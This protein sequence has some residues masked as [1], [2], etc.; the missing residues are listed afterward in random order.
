MAFFW[1]LVFSGTVN[2][3]SGTYLI[4]NNE[5]GCINY[6]SNGNPNDPRKKLDLF[7]DIENAP[8]IRVCE[9]KSVDYVMNGANIANVQWSAAGG[10]VTSVSGT[11]N[12][13]ATVAWGAP[14]NG[15]LTLTITYSN[16]SQATTSVCIE[17]IN[18]P[19]ALFEILGFDEPVFCL[20]TPINFENLSINNGG[21]DIVQYQWDFGDGNYSSTFEP[22]HSYTLPGD[23][24]VELTVTNNCNCSNKYKLPVKIIDRPNVT[25]SCPS[26]VCEDGDKHT[27]TV[28]DECGGEWI[29]EGGHVVDQTPTSVTV[30]WDVVDASGFGTISYK[31][32]CACPFWTTVKIPVIKKIGTII[33]DTVLCVNQQG[34]YT[35]PQWPS[36]EFV[37][38]L[39]PSSPTG[40]HIVF[41]DQRNQ[42]IV[43]ALAAGS[44]VLKCV[45]TNT[46]LGCS[47]TAE[48]KI[49]VVAGTVITGGLDTLCS[50]TSSTY[51]TA[52]GGSVQ[53]ELK[54]NNAVVSSLTA[55]SFTYNFPTGGVYTLTATTGGCISEPKVINVTQ[56]P[57]APTG[58]L[59]GETKYCPGV[60]YDYS[61]TNTVPNTILEWTVTNGTIQGDNTGNNVTIVFNN[62]TTAT[63]TVRRRSLDGLGCLSPAFSVVVN[64]IVIT[65]TITPNTTGVKFCPS[66]ATTFN[67]NLNGNTADLLEWS[68]IPANFGNVISGIN[69][70]TVT[71]SWNEISTSATG[72]LRLKITKCGTITTVDTPIELQQSPNLVLTAPNQLCSSDPN[73]NLTLSA[74][75]ITT[76]TITWDFGNG[77]TTTTPLSGSSYTFANPYNNTT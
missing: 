23:Y 40:T 59:V 43:D 18:G 24:M 69:N 57:S 33:G 54:K 8:C 47:G 2:A 31:S 62:T 14:G 45:Y 75:G 16:G 11:A 73:L 50:G 32:G 34:L 19:K 28:D 51:T 68:V 13:N 29:I 46:L 37:W 66:S 76:G 72:T 27:Y 1:L 9:G 26:V 56:T 36:T 30:V 52:G 35:L 39:T 53:W 67:V 65:P 3:Q 4:W 60:P 6:D 71:V 22:T 48:I 20:D 15:A 70:N 64:K 12:K 41:N 74:T 49:R 63:I 61:L 5:V 21:S 42:V 7:Q 10:T 77:V 55:V 58:S 17:I 25:I 38:T 44:Y